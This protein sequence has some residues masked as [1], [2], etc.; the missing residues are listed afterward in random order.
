MPADVEHFA[1]VTGGGGDLGSAQHQGPVVDDGRAGLGVLH[2]LQPI[3]DYVDDV[4]LGVGQELDDS[5]LALGLEL[6][7]GQKSVGEIQRVGNADQD[8][9]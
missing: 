4:V 1:Y 7:P 9:L 6:E 3:L 2:T 5:R 8:E